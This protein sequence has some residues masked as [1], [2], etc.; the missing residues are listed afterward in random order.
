MLRNILLPYQGD[1]ASD[2]A[3]ATAWLVAQQFGSYVEGFFAIQPPP[4]IASEGVT[5]PGEYVTQ[6]ADEARQMATEARAR[7]ERVM[8]ERGAP[9]NETPSEP[10]A[11]SS[12]WHEEEGIESDLVGSY[13]RLFDLVVMPCSGKGS[14]VDQKAACEA[15]LFDSGRPVLVASSSPP[16]QLGETIVVAWNGSTET[17]RTLS[18]GMPLLERASRVIVL[19]VE[20]ATVPGP[21][22]DRVAASLARNGVNASAV[23]ADTGGRVAGEVMLEQAHA[24]GA[25][26][27]IKGAYTQSR[28]REMIFG[29]ATRHILS[30]ADLPV[31]MSH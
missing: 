13:G 11:P 10:D 14:S 23:S 8:A 9:V 3:L 17:A 28:L 30:H 27:L 16:A 1:E 7:F 2:A 25:D 18:M 21:D 29:G 20:G 15:A 6:L 26:L 19:T 24:L 31:L 4:I 22:G 12:G 5:L